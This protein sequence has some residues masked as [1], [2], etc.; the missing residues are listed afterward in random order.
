MTQERKW[1]VRSATV[2]GKL[3]K[4]IP[5]AKNI[6]LV[7]MNAR[8]CTART[9]QIGQVFNPIT[10]SVTTLSHQTVEQVA[11]I[12]KMAVQMARR[13]VKDQ[14]ISD[15]NERFKKVKAALEKDAIQPPSKLQS[16]VKETDTEI[17]NSDHI[18]IEIRKNLL[19]ETDNL[20]RILRPIQFISMNCCIEAARIP[21]FKDSFT[22]I[23]Q[24]ISDTHHEIDGILSGCLTLM[25]S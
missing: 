7:A 18:M 12:E 4:I 1:F 13:A 5:L 17:N 20:Y 14:H 24:T 23:A 3:S 15:S 25:E 9:G 10:Q 8:V 22:S 2:T 16:L 6:A 21:E 19:S 11:I